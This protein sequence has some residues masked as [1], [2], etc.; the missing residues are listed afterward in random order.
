[1]LNSIRPK[2]RVE[3]K[4]EEILEFFKDEKEIEKVKDR[5]EIVKKALNK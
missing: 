4:D 3:F 5:L 2:G 1:M